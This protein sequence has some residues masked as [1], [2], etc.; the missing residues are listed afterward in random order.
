VIQPAKSFSLGEHYYPA[1]IGDM[2]NPDRI[3]ADFPLLREAHDRND[4]LI[5]RIYIGRKF[6][7]DTERLE[8]LFALYAQEQRAIPVN[9]LD[10]CDARRRR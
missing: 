10:L 7:N 1:T 6:K 4:G 3:D 2:Y 5:E 9:E 8:K